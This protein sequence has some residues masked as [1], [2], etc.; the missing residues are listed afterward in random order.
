[1]GVIN[2]MY[3]NRLIKFNK[4][5]ILMQDVDNRWTVRGVWGIMGTT[6][7]SIFSK[8]KTVLKAVY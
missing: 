2:D 7:D 3:Y 1:M 5:T 6:I 4:F 8:S